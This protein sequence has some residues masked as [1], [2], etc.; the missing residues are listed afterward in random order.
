MASSSSNYAFYSCQQ[1]VWYLSSIST[2]FS[3]KHVI[4]FESGYSISDKFACVSS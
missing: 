3:I 2:Q 1:M 4:I